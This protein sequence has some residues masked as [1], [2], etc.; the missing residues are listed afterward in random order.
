MP[1]Q[2]IADPCRPQQVSSQGLHVDTEAHGSKS[3]D[4]QM[5]DAGCAIHAGEGGFDPSPPTIFIAELWGLFHNPSGSQPHGLFAATQVMML[6][7]G[8]DWAD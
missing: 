2:G 4:A 3:S 7:A 6:A 5:L 1:P 8:L